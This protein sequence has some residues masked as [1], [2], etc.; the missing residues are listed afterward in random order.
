TFQIVPPDAKG[1]KDSEKLLIMSVV[2][3][4]GSCECAGVECDR[5]DVAIRGN[6]G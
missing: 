5:V 1:F 4:F 6:G 3:E 2:V